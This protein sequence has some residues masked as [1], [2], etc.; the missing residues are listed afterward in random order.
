MSTG[1][2]EPAKNYMQFSGDNLGNQV[3]DPNLYQDGFNNGDGF[4]ALQQDGYNAN[5]RRGETRNFSYAQDNQGYPIVPLNINNYGGTVN[6]YT[7]GGN[8]YD[9]AACRAMQAAKLA[10]MTSGRWD[11]YDDSGRQYL[12][13]NRISDA[14]RELLIRDGRRQDD[15]YRANFSRDFDG[16]AYNRPGQY[17]NY[18]HGGRDGLSYYES[19]PSYNSGL[20]PWVN[21]DCFGTGRGGRNGDMRAFQDVFRTVAPFIVSMQ[22]RHHGGGQWDRGRD[23]RDNGMNPIEYML[24]DRAINGGRWNR[25]PRMFDERVAYS[26]GGRDGL[27]YYNSTP[28][29][30]QWSGPRSGFQEFA[31]NVMPIFRDVAP[32]VV[33]MKYANDDGSYRGNQNVDNY[34][35]NGHRSTQMAYNRQLH[36]MRAQRDSDRI[37]RNRQMAMMRRER[38]FG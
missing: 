36:D 8:G 37:Q 4:N 9:D 17:T 5:V 1:E 13:N 22:D 25:N 35:G 21:D 7:A 14:R 26:H 6:V 16:R 15:M 19:G 2:F 38:D 33:A 10:D 24:M 31:D 29:Y 18:S 30:D 27:T 11:N 12:E 32:F 28:T 3:E 34:Y 20:P 23:Y